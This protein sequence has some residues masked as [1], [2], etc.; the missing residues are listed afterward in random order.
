MSLSQDVHHLRTAHEEHCTSVHAEH[1]QLR[2]RAKN[3]H[4]ENTHLYDIA[5]R[6]LI[7]ETLSNRGRRLRWVRCLRDAT[8]EQLTSHGDAG[9]SF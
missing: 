9:L 7:V 6:P 2:R 8:R 4:D 3:I 1:P 5:E